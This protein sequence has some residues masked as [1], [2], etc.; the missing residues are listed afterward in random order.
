MLFSVE[1]GRR[2]R[3]LRTLSCCDCQHKTR[4]DVGEKVPGL[5]YAFPAQLRAS[6]Q[7]RN[8]AGFVAFAPRRDRRATPDVEQARAR[9]REYQ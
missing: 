8:G 5:S 1:I 9:K 3:I 6:D 4:A 7:S 2:R